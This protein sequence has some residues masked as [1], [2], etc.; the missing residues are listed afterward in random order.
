MSVQSPDAE[1]TSLA[2]FLTASLATS[3]AQQLRRSCRV[4]TPTTGAEVTIDGQIYLHFS[5]NDYL[6][7][8]NDARVIASATAALQRYGLGSGASRLLGGTS[9]V[10][11]ALEE[12]LAAFLDGESALVFSSGYLANLGLLSSLTTAEDI[13]ICDRLNHASL[14]D[15]ARLSRATLRVYPHGDMAQL[16]QVLK[17][18]TSA[19]HRLIVTDGVFSMD[20]DI[21]PLAELA[22][23]AAQTDAWLY[24]DDAHGSFVLGA[25]G[26]GTA[27]LCGVEQ[28]VTHMGTLGKAL[29]ALGGYVVGSRAL[30]DHLVNSARS[31]IYATALPPAVA[32]GATTAIDI[33]AAEPERRV[34]VAALAARLRQGLQGQG[35]DTLGST[36]H[37]VPMLVGS[38]PAALRVAEALRMAG[39]YAPAIRSPTVPQGTARIRWSL[40]AAHTDAQID[41]C[42]DV[43]ARI[44]RDEGIGT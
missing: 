32:A 19:R 12:R 41:R 40:S 2:Q 16:A 35:W 7:V 38:I 24:V 20:G 10:H 31:F 33:V 18:A 23:L 13:I 3:N 30:I 37:I 27:E 34:R 39:I 21:A 44:A 26:R 1:T 14:I 6:G 25:H 4:L 36:T 28:H 11:A 8:A 43:C 17:R 15:G 9:P 29:G 42:L 5:S 22:A